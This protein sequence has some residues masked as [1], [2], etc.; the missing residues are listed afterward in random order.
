MRWPKLPS[1]QFQAK[2][3]GILLTLFSIN[4]VYQSYIDLSNINSINKSH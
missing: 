4:D 2:V 1:Q 3:T